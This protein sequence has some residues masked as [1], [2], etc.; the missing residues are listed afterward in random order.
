MR[1]L[2]VYI[3]PR[4]WLQSEHCHM[5]V[6]THHVDAARMALSRGADDT[7][8]ETLSMRRLPLGL[9]RTHC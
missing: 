7:G 1:E 2:F 3:L 4:F 5:A 9:V 6:V 8:G